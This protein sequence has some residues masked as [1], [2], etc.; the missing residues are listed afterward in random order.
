MN[1]PLVREALPE[2]TV[3]P[4]EL[5]RQVM[6]QGPLVYLHPAKSDISGTPTLSRIHPSE[7]VP[8]CTLEEFQS[9]IV[10]NRKVGKE[11]DFSR[12]FFEQYR[13]IMRSSYLPPLNNANNDN[14]SFTTA[15]FN[16]KNAYLTF[17]CFD[18]E[19]CL[20]S[21]CLTRA[22]E[23][24]DCVAVTDCELCVECIDCSG[25]YACIASKDCSD[26]CRNL[27]G[28]EDMRGSKDCYGCIGMEHQQFCIFNKQA[29]E[30]EYKAFL[31]KKHLHTFS[32]YQ[33]ALQECRAFHASTGHKA[34]RLINCTNSTGWYLRDCQNVEYG[35]D[36]KGAENCGFILN[37]SDKA[38]NCWF[39]FNTGSQNCYLGTNVGGNEV[40]YSYSSIGGAFNIYCFML[41]NGCENCF[42]SVGLKKNSYCILNKQYTKEEY[43]ALVPRIIE[44]MKSTGEWGKVIPPR[45]AL[46]PALETNIELYCQTQSGLGETELARRGYRVGRTP[47]N[48]APADA[49]D[50]E[51]IPESIQETSPEMLLGKV[52]RCPVTGKPLTFQAKEIAVRLKL[53]VPLPRIHW[54]KRLVDRNQE[55][56][57]IPLVPN[58]L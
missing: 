21:Y 33:A 47:E 51:N 54:R 1:H 6:C 19:D 12:P 43:E 8:M 36:T 53:G 55:R 13:E 29:T 50:I 41:Q 52:F 35:H 56:D 44:H 20:Y 11:Y 37:N 9:D 4:F 31:Q 2:P 34:N 14:C 17:V 40:I 39:G 49:L 45:M 15:T 5:L 46:A 23:C 24:V 30:E 57:L 38:R 16:S 42:G 7:G 48:E 18:S 26:G 32:G 58:I 27:F 10:D 22:R 3:H 25:C 28:C